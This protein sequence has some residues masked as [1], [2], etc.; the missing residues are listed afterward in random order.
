MIARLDVA[1]SIWQLGIH[2][3]LGLAGT[4]TEGFDLAHIELR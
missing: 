2:H 3:R 4:D 1:V